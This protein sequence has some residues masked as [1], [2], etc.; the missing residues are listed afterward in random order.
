MPANSA[1]ASEIWLSVTVQY[2]LNTVEKVKKKEEKSL[3]MHESIYNY[4]LL[5]SPSS[6]TPSRFTLHYGLISRHVPLVKKKTRKGTTHEHGIQGGILSTAT[7]SVQN[8]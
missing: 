6:S 1:T 5:F 8:G 2:V 3:K 4:Y 7:P